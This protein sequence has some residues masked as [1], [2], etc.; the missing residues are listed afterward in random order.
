MVLNQEGIATRNQNERQELK[1]PS[2]KES[3]VSSAQIFCQISV[4]LEFLFGHSR[5]PNRSFVKKKS[6]G[7]EIKTG[8][9]SSRSGHDERSV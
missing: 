8:Q 3:R 1:A 7:M 5:E 9:L 6:N 2:L 4:C